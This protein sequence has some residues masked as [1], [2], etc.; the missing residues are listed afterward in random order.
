MTGSRIR[1]ALTPSGGMRLLL[2]E[3]SYLGTTSTY[4]TQGEYR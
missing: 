1:A 2:T 4:T 3:A